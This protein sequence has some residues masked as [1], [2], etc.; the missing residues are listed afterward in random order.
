MS[1]NRLESLP[2]WAQRHIA[3]LEAD[4]ATLKEELRV[5]ETE[6]GSGVRIRHLLDKT[7]I[8]A[9]TIIE[10]DVLDDVLSISRPSP[11]AIEIRARESGIVISPHVSNVIHVSPRPRFRRVSGVAS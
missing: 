6:E 4:N 5:L 10:F 2:K 9:N 11:E 3:K 7:D 1:A 8:P